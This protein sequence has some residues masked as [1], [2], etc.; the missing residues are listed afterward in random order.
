M[1]G[2]ASGGDKTNVPGHWRQQPA[3]MMRAQ[4]A[5]IQTTARPDG[6]LTIYNRMMGMMISIYYSYKPSYL[7]HP[8][9]MN[10]RGWSV[11]MMRHCW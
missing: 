5:F 11:V 8:T 9:S 2:R 1:N 10:T 4:P 7:L 3:F 6:T